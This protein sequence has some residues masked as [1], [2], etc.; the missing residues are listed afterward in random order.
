M[1]VHQWGQHHYSPGGALSYLGFL[2]VTA[3]MCLLINLL[4][5][6]VE[7]EYGSY[8]ACDHNYMRHLRTLFRFFLGEETVLF[9][10]DGNTDWEMSCGSLQGLYA[11]IDFGTGA[12]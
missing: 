2:I 4:L 12:V 1:A 5:L 3:L 9:T 7:N 6:Q 10:T 8:F 11:T